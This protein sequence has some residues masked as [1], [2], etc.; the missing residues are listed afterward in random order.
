[1]RTR[2][3]SGKGGFTVAAVKYGGGGDAFSQVSGPLSALRTFFIVIAA[4][5]FGITGKFRSQLNYVVKT[6]RILILFFSSHCILD[7]CISGAKG[8]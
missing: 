3:A 4:A 2:R 6:S 1:M 5:I 7:C 8:C